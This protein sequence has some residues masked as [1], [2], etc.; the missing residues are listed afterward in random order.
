MR[1]EP[2]GVLFRA[3]IANVSEPFPVSEESMHRRTTNSGATPSLANGA[4]S[5]RLSRHLG[6]ALFPKINAIRN[7]YRFG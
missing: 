4:P 6:L 5:A 3:L 2:L 1:Q 7:E